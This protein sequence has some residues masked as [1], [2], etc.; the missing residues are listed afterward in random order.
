MAPS[1]SRPSPLAPA[2]YLGEGPRPDADGTVVEQSSHRVLWALGQGC[3]WALQSTVQGRVSPIV[4]GV[5]ADAAGK[6]QLHDGGVATA[7]GQVQRPL[8]VLVRSISLG[9]S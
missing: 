8:L 4:H 5:G 3:S 9:S 6:Q 7:T 2:P 1:P